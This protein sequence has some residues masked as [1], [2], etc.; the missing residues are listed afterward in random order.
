M[1]EAWAIRGG[2]P[3]T[4]FTEFMVQAKIRTSYCICQNYTSIRH[5][6]LLSSKIGHS[7]A[8]HASSM[9]SRLPMQ[10]I[11]FDISIHITSYLHHLASP[12]TL[13]SFLSL[14][15]FCSLDIAWLAPKHWSWTVFEDAVKTKAN[16]LHHFHWLVKYVTRQTMYSLFA[17]RFIAQTTYDLRSLTF[18]FCT[19]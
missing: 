15:K 17:M 12:E 9:H 6:S 7:Q 16:R 1:A 18:R 8:V 10:N 19:H 5:E 3:M 4:G 11:G 2:S 13:Q 14:L